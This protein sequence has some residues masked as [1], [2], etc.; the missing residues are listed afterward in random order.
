MYS[1]LPVM[2]R[3]AV[4]GVK[5]PLFRPLTQKDAPGSG[6]RLSRSPYELA[7]NVEFGVPASGMAAENAEVLFESTPVVVAVKV[8]PGAA[9]IIG[10][11][12]VTVPC[13]FVVTLNDWRKFCPCPA[14]LPV[15]VAKNSIT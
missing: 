7:T 3:T 14:V 4:T 10:V 12:N 9:G 2:P 8:F 6:T 15:G 13:A 5:A 11:T 1:S